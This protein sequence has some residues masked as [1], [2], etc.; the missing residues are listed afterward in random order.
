MARHIL[1]IAALLLGSSFLFFAGG[2]NA[3]VLP[4]RGNGEGFSTFSL[5][6]L[7]TGWAIGY[8]TGCLL[9][10]RL[11]ARVG[12]IRTFSVLA[13][14][15]GLAISSSLLLLT[16]WAWIPLRAVSGFCFSGAAMVVEGWLSER[17]ETATRGTVFGIYTMVNLAATTAGQMSLTLGDPMSYAYFVV[18]AMFYMLALIPT[19]VSSSATP[20]PLIQARL[21]LK[22]LYRN[23][24]VA[25]VAVFF[26]GVSNSSF[27]TL[28]AIYATEVGLSLAVVA[29]FASLPLLAGAIA[30]V[31][32][33][34]I[35]D[36]ID[37]RAVLIAVALVAIA[38][39]V[40]FIVARPDE[41]QLALISVALLGAAIFTMYPVLVAHANDHATPETYILTSGGL[42]LVFGVGS[43][44]GPLAAGGAMQFAG[45]RGLFFVTASAHVVIVLY[46]LWRMRQRAAVPTEEKAAFVA[47]PSARNTTP[48]TVVLAPQL[49]LPEETAGEAES[50]KPATPQGQ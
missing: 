37:R 11:V 12:H 28:S 21:D 10:P 45:P 7:G 44:V 1:P 15:A 29:L 24:P 8:V 42:L 40:T 20:H 50:S 4:L 43:I 49:D 16:P 35:S 23:S 6:L 14:M 33:G 13:A 27:G 2:M 41:A 30:Q 32:I 46:A 39:D 34:M 22:A 25:V 9:V 36:R 19:A 17:S 5:G 26:V 47:T 3:L 48:Q 38:A 18:A 31:P